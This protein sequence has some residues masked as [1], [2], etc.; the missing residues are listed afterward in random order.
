MK[1]DLIFHVK[2]RS[3]Q[4]S[5]AGLLAASEA[6]NNFE[7]ALEESPLLEENMTAMGPTP[8]AVAG[9]ALMTLAALDSKGVLASMLAH[10]PLSEWWFF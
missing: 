2:R 4:A 3:K 7:A 8:E 10:E 5:K 6:L 9:V 1:G